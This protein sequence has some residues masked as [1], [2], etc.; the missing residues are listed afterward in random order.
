M[1]FS[2]NLRGQTLSQEQ[3]D[4]I[5]PVVSARMQ[6]RMSVKKFEDAC[7]VALEAAGCPLDATDQAMAK[8]E[9]P[10]PWKVAMDEQRR[11]VMLEHGERVIEFGGVPAIEAFAAEHPE[12]PKATVNE[13]LARNGG[14]SEV[15]AVEGG[16]VVQH[17]ERWDPLHRI[18]LRPTEGEA[19]AAAAEAAVTQFRINEGMKRCEMLKNVLAQRYPSAD[20]SFGYIGNL[21]RWGDDR[22][23]R[24]FTGILQAPTNDG[25]GIPRREQFGSVATAQLPKLADKA[26]AEL[27]G[28]LRAKLKIP[29]AAAVADARA[30]SGLPESSNVSDADESPCP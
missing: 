11:M 9:P 10:S 14:Y 21:E 30:T 4:A 23:W 16:W 8:L 27:E 12:V 24:F 13:L 18:G 3:L 20:L 22:S 7:V 29:E 1:T 25:W 28:W 2:M 19:W 5:V 6:T 15:K 17:T 26:E